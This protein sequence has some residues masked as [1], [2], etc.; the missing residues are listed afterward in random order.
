MYV[1]TDLLKRR[2]KKKIRDRI[3]RGKCEKRLKGQ[4]EKS[5]MF[6]RISNA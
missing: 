4:E 1:Y 6:S 3:K 5:D 2:K